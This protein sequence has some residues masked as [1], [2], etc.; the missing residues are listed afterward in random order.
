[1]TSL[2]EYI[3]TT[4]S[5]SMAW[6]GPN[7]WDAGGISVYFMSSPFWC[8]RLA[9]KIAFQ[10][11]IEKPHVLYLLSCSS[12]TMGISSAKTWHRASF[13]SN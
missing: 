1:M 3:S 10:R 4:G 13:A 6:A 12:G 11:K 5:Q 9:S 7:C 8:P 2:V